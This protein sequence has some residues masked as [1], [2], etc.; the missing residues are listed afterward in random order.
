V[1]GRRIVVVALAVA[2]A[3]TAAASAAGPSPRALYNALLASHV[4][5]TPA[6]VTQ[7]G[8]TSRRHHVIGEMLVN[9]SGGRTRLA[10][11]V[12]PKHADA[13]G[14]YADGL[15][16]LKK[17]KS[18]RKIEKTVPG[19][20]KPSVLVDASQNGLGVTQVTFVSDNV[21]LVS[22]SIKVNA[23]GGDEKQAKRLALLALRHLQSVEKTA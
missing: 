15:L 2:L 9:F 6:T 13:L 3:C 21:E 20:P 14:N 4:N 10:Y 18:V 22:Q 1:P 7:T 16:A 5:G 17:I 19:L 11:V 23:I 8:S 12:F